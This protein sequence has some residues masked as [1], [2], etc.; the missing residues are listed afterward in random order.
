MVKWKKF[1]LGMMFL[2]VLG[3]SA[4]PAFAAELEVSNVNQTLTGDVARTVY[5]NYKTA[6]TSSSSVKQP[7]TRVYYYEHGAVFDLET[8]SYVT[9]NAE[10]YDRTG[11]H[12]AEI[13]NLMPGKRY[14]YRIYD[15][16]SRNLSREYSFT[17]K[18]ENAG[19]VS[20]IATADAYYRTTSS[21]QNFYGNTLNTALKQTPDAGFFLHTGKANSSLSDAKH[22]DGF[23]AQAA[24]ALETTPIVPSTVSAGSSNRFF[25]LNYNLSYN[26]YDLQDNYFE[27]GDM[28]FLSLNSKLTSTANI[29]AHK[30]WLNQAV[31]SAGN[32]KWII[33]SIG[34][35]FYGTGSSSSTIKTQLNQTFRELGVSLVIQGDDE[36]YTRSNPIDN[37]SVLYDYAGEKSIAAKDGIIYLSPGSAGAEQSNGNTGRNWIR[38]ASDFSASAVRK[39][40]EKKMY[41][42]VTVQN[43]KL[44]VTAYTVDGTVVDEFEI[45]R[46]ETPEREPKD[47]DFTALN[48]AFGTDAKTARTITWQ[49]DK[50][51]SSA[52]VE[53]VE[54]GEA[55][56]KEN[57]AEYQ[58]ATTSNTGLFT[59]KLTNKVKLE[60]LTAGTT[61]QYRL[62]NSYVNP[63]TKS[64]T[65][66]YSSVYDFTT[67]PENADSYTFL[68]VSDSQGGST[69]YEKFWRNTLSQGLNKYP[70]APFVIQNGDMVDSVNNTHWTNYFAATGDLL[71]SAAFAPVL[72]NHEAKSYEPFYK[73]VFSVEAMNGYPLNYSFSYGNGLF[74]NLNANYDT[75]SNLQV[76]ANWMKQVAA[77]PENEGKFIIV[78]FHKNPYG[79]RWTSQS[80]GSLASRNIKKYLY[81]EMEKLGV[82][83]V[84]SGHDHNYIRS[85]PVKNNTQNTS[86]TDHGNISTSRD[87]LVNM[88]TRNSGEKTYDPVKKANFPW[89]DVLWPET[90]FSSNVPENTMFAAITVTKDKLEVSAMTSSYQL[91]DKYT[92]TK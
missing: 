78:T 12:K 2:F 48:N 15:T 50:T 86:I 35:S 77:Q 43:D 19:E 42:K 56:S 63:D 11:Y 61:Y 74:F 80:S 24:S 40:A 76:Q 9:A 29:S 45:T 34:D 7:E 8:A 69:S 4:S 55:F 1:A 89:I 51:M 20:F 92:I 91:I 49:T 38:K 70:E 36:A 72:G 82:N 27:Y 68:N 81:P 23:F 73:S 31:S 26:N 64:V 39:T 58:G 85:Y 44:L 71:S 3:I 66:Y 21:Y 84:L 16:V 28:L 18:E 59:S 6:R 62:R 30:A 67:E 14:L 37:K 5:L 65:Y 46:G 22:W 52:A 60:K 10:V 90:K 88:I 17:T 25:K 33:V 83:L 13:K 41:T 79:G 75:Q 32:G 53:L 87:G 57:I 54:E 47:L